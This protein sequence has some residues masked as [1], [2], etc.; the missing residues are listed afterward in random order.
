MDF[1]SLS[2][3]LRIE[4]FCHSTNSAPAPHSLLP[5][6]SLCL[7]EIPLLR[8]PISSSVCFHV[9][10]FVGLAFSLCSDLWFT[11]LLSHSLG[12]RTMKIFSCSELICLGWQLEKLQGCLAKPSVPY[13][14]TVLL[15]QESG[16]FSCQHLTNLCWVLAIWGLLF[17]K[18]CNSADI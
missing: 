1:G 14:G 8:P 18:P 12:R 3:A 2:K 13:A 5:L 16:K 11:I 7:P 10:P 17:A 6:S 15:Q 4:T 9:I